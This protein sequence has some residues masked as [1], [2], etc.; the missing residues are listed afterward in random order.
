MKVRVVV[1]LVPVVLLVIAL[2]GG[3]SLVLRLFFLS[4][5]VLLV[6]YLWTLLGIRGVRVQ[7]EPPPEHCQVGKRLRQENSYQ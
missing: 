1:I 5:L 7:A 3:S 2:L 6:S 4:V